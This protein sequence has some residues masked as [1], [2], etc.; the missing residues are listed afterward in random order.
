MTLDLFRKGV[1][2]VRALR[3]AMH[4]DR[5]ALEAAFAAMKA[6][7][8]FDGIVSNIGSAFLAKLEDGN[9]ELASI[10]STVQEQTT[11]LDDV[12]HIT[13]RSDFRMRDLRDGYIT[14]ILVLPGMR[15]ATHFRW[16]RLMI[17]AALG[18]LERF[19]V[20]RDSPPVLFMLEEFA[21][22]GQMRSIES[23]AGL[24][25]GYGVK[26]WPVLQD[27]SQLKTHYPKSWET[28]IGNA[29]LIQAFANTDLG[30]TDVLSRMLGMTRVTE[31][32]TVRV[33]SASLASGDDG[34]RETS[35]GV[36]L[37]EPDEITRF[38][39]R[40]TNRQLLIIPGMRPMYLER[41]DRYGSDRQSP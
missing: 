15:I 26:L 37:L 39:A 7:D 11:S 12:L 16:L 23:A 31:R 9:R 22:L 40:E 32:Q 18:A 14:I 30:T 41:N 13:D 8:A 36:R 24:M 3:K 38:F 35:R 28:F 27:L 1:P 5:P 34:V 17:Q 21:A 4:A 6:S 25:A 10:M 2:T 33:S 29:G 19:P 20:A